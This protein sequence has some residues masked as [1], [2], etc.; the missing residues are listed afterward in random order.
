VEWGGREG[1]KK[2]GGGVVQMREELREQKGRNTGL[3]MMCISLVYVL[4]S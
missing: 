4:K 1:K 2:W 3:K